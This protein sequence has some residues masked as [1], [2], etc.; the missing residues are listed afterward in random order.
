WLHEDKGAP[1]AL[2]YV[3]RVDEGLHLLRERLI[4]W[5]VTHA[6]EY[7]RD[8]SE[9]EQRLEGPWLDDAESP[10][11]P[12]PVTQTTTGSLPGSRPSSREQRVLNQLERRVAWT[13]A[14]VPPVL[15]LIAI[16]VMAVPAVVLVALDA[17][18]HGLG[19][20]AP[21]VVLATLL[22]A[23]LSALACW[24]VRRTA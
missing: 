3:E 4:A 14:R 10:A 22:V 8:L 17:L 6:N 15:N 1:Y 19:L 24:L 9:V 21:V 12:A 23:A 2:A 7:E 5:R 16:C 13:E 20:Q 11:P 18:P